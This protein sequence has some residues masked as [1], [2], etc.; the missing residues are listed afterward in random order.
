[1]NYCLDNIMTHDI[2]LSDAKY[3]LDAILY[4]KR[5]WNQAKKKMQRIM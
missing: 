4:K 1:M 2:S 3:I 5:P